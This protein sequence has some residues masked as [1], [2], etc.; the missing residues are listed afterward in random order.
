MFKKIGLIVFIFLLSIVI[1]IFSSAYTRKGPDYT[2]M[3]NLGMS[4]DG[5]EVNCPELSL[6]GGFPASY[7]FD[8]ASTSV[9]GSVSF[10]EDD[11]RI[12]PFIANTSFYFVILLGLW[13]FLSFL[14]N[15]K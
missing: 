7:L 13:N 6:S 5:I 2:L 10:L 9:V 1:A 8:V 15:R 11:F 12:Y 14:R 3:C 4:P